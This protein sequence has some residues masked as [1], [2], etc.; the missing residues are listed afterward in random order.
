MADRIEDSAPAT[1]NLRRLERIQGGL[2]IAAVLVLLVFVV[3]IVVSYFQLRRIRREIAEQQAIIS[4]KKQEIKEIEEALEN[5]KKVIS[6]LQQTTLAITEANPADGAS[7]REAVEQSLAQVGDIRQLPA[8][9]YMQIARKDQQRRAAAIARA[10]QAAGY[11]VPGIENV[12]DKAPNTSQLR[13]CDG[14]NYLPEDLDAITKVLDRISVSVTRQRLPRCGNVR[15]RH[16][17]IWL[18]ESY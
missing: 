1:L 18:G 8:R 15:P 5:R 16:Y 14:D 11:I 10:L 13:Y 3:L 6:G 4:Q 17:E 9:I 2:R 7:T 12:R